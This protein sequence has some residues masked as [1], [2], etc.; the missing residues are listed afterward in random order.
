MRRMPA[1]ARPRE[2]LAQ[3]GASSLSDV[4]LVALVIGS[5]RRGAS[6]VDVAGEL[7]AEHGSLSDLR[8]ARPE[9][10]ARVAAIGD[11]KAAGIVAAFELGRRAE[12]GRTLHPRIRGPADIAAVVRPHLLEARREESFVL[13]LDGAHRVRKTERM[14]TGGQT[15]CGFE[16]R[17]VLGA[18][19]RH[20]G[21]ALGLVHS[22]PSG[23]TAP[24]QEDVAATRALATAA[25]QVGLRLVDHVIV[26]GPRWTGLASLGY[27]DS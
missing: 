27:L 12:G 20:D 22:H 17:D 16:T 4:E 23:D 6:A 1:E 15:A 5:G 25:G 2:R 3:L 26:S 14:A 24:S 9:E 21:C 8:R 18:V 11:A 19:L 10:L 7:L 13:V